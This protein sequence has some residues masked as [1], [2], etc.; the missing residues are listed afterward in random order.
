MFAKELWPAPV[1]WE[2]CYNA[3][4][5]PYAAPS[6]GFFH[7]HGLLCSRVA[8]AAFPQPPLSAD[9]PPPH[10]LLRTLCLPEHF[11]TAHTVVS[12]HVLPMVSCLH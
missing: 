8:L 9:L 6:L 3:F 11:P 10:V 7:V 12:G 5:G 1:P 4:P 2:R